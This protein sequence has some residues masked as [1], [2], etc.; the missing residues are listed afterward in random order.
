[1][2]L[3]TQFKW[4]TGSTSLETCCEQQT[5]KAAIPTGTQV[6]RNKSAG[7]Y[8]EVPSIAE[9][10]WNQ[11]WWPLD[12]R[13][14]WGALH[15][16]STFYETWSTKNCVVVELQHFK[17]NTSRVSILVS[18]MFCRN[19]CGKLTRVWTTQVWQTCSYQIYISSTPSKKWKLGLLQLAKVCM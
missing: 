1:M 18:R 3:E 15:S 5:D 8:P 14:V 2:S 11:N 17:I 16:G 6:F 4:Q 19:I 7:Q 10:V 13:K 9:C 12:Y